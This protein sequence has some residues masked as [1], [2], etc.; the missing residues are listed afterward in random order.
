MVKIELVRQIITYWYRVQ[1]YKIIY[2]TRTFMAK[3]YNQAP[4]PFQGQKRKFLKHFQTALKQHFNEKYTYVDLFGGSGLLSHFVHQVYPAATVVYNDFDNYSERLRHIPETNALLAR[5]RGILNDCQK[6]KL[7]PPP[8]RQQIIE[9]ITE[10]DKKG[11]VDYITLS[12]NLM[13]S[14]KYATNLTDFL[15]E[16]FYNNVRQADYDAAG[17]LDV[18]H[19]VREDYKTLFARY[20]HRPDVVFLIDPPYLSTD[21]GTYTGYWKLK[22]YL[23]VLH[24]L[25]E[26]NY[27]YFTSNKSSIVELCTWLEDNMH[28]SNPF[29]GAQ[30]VEISTT[31]NAISRYTDIMLYLKRF[32]VQ[33]KRAG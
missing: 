26:T 8:L 11:F 31:V 7:I 20:R 9:I 2:K 25:K 32:D 16:S 4:L 10:A 29:S 17:Y 3:F 5:M 15:K 14:M 23:D 27:F 18:I 33:N 21:A 30:K 1:I 6:E 22:D 12:S 13:F 19:I 28:S 24:T